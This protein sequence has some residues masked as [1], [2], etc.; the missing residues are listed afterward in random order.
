MNKIVKLFKESI[1][2][3]LKDNIK[4]AITALIILSAPFVTSL[5]TTL[6]NIEL[7]FNLPVVIGVI[8]LTIILMLV[9][10]QISKRNRAL[11]KEIYEIQN[12]ANPN[13]NKFS[14]GD[15]VI[16]KIEAE[17]QTPEK[18]SVVGKTRSEIE[19]RKADAQTLKLVP[20]ELLTSTETEEV[21]A[22]IKEQR[23]A[24]AKVLSQKNKR[25]QLS[26]GIEL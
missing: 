22:K 25:R 3:L 13:V 24:M 9:I 10:V 11:R 18:L 23:I 1:W 8:A 15:I 21:F 14:K 5:F 17:S 2:D 7:T 19:C 12:P 20:E 6:K 16:R 4:T 26:R